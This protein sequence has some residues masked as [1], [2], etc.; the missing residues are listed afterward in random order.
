MPV[1]V[2]ASSKGGVGK[3]TSALS[4]AFVLAHHGAKTTLVDAD[5]NAPLVRWAE[6]FPDGIPQGLT[7]KAG[8]GS[9]AAEIIDASSDPFTVVDLEGSKN[10]EVSVGLGRAD[11][12]LIPMKGS[13]LDADEAAAVIKLIKRQEIVFRRRIPYRVFF[14]QTS[15]AIMDKGMRD[16]SA[17][18]RD[19][20][21]PMLRTAMVDRAAFKAPFRL[22]GSFYDL[23]QADVRNPDAAI[24]NAEEFA[25]EIR[26]CL[27]TEA[28]LVGEGANA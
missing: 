25:T 2:F 10:I 19:Q 16:I 13:Q 28:N 3:T 7:I 1:I 17:Q 9:E 20:G 5:P 8:L 22:G 21:I 6:R 24:L 23:T 4:L 12:A 18:L 26:D 15:P 27:V 14:S 11:L